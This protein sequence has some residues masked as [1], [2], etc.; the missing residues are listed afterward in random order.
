MVDSLVVHMALLWSRNARSFDGGG[1]A[2]VQN[3]DIIA[4]DGKK[5]L[6]I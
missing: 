5:T 4:I 1:I 3:G 6:S 2:L